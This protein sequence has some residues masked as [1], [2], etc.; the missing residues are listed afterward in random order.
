MAWKLDLLLFLCVRMCFI[1][2]IGL[3]STHCN[4]CLLSG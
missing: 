1:V 2:K 4:V 3:I